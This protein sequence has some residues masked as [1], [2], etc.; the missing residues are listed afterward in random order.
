M[1][2]MVNTTE[3][4]VLGYNTAIQLAERNGGT[5]TAV[6]LRR[7]GPPPYTD[8]GMALKY[9]TYNNLL[10]DAMG[11]TRLEMVLLI[12]PQLAREYGLWDRANFDRGLIESFAAVYP[13]LRE[14]DFMTEANTVDLPMFFLHGRN[15]VNAMA[16]L[17]ERY[18]N[19]LH[20]PHKELIWTESG[21]GASAQEILDT[22]VNRVLPQTM[23]AP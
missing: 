8:D 20:A 1:G 22:M 19:A 11:N 7:N 6:T 15:D 5:N 14:L 12:V 4:D 13:Q 18:Y 23:P 16:P 21:H 3:N 9:A 17:V 2:Q 10:F